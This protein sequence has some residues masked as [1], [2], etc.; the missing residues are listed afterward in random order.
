MVSAVPS[1]RSVFT[2]NSAIAA[3]SEGN[4]GRLGADQQGLYMTGNARSQLDPDIWEM[5]GMMPEIVPERRTSAPTSSGC[6][7]S[8]RW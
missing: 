5:P 8:G 3:V 7:P 1:E 4:Y 2:L 6:S